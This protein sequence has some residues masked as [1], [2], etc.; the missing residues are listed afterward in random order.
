MKFS[1]EKESGRLAFLDVLR[2]FAFASVL[3]GHK[4]YLDLA[5][6]ICRQ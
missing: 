2:V 3:V 6:G 5:S 1:C 4:L